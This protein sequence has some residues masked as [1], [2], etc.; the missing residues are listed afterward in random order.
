MIESGRSLR[1]V[2]IPLG[3]NVVP[4]SSMRGTLASFSNNTSDESSNQGPSSRTNIISPSLVRVVMGICSVTPLV[5][6]ILRRWTLF[7]QNALPL[8]CL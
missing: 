8:G 5:K 1:S 2:S 6:N 7:S 4:E 3:V